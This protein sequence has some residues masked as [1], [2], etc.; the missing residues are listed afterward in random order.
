MRCTDIICVLCNTNF[1]RKRLTPTLDS[2]EYKYLHSLATMLKSTFVSDDAVHQPYTKTLALRFTPTWPA[3]TLSVFDC[4]VREGSSYDWRFQTVGRYIG[5]VVI[6]HDTPLTTTHWAGYR[7]SLFCCTNM[8]V[9]STFCAS[10]PVTNPVMGVWHMP[11]HSEGFTAR[12][13]ST[14]IF[15]N[16]CLFGS[17]CSDDKTCI[18]QGLSTLRGTI[19]I[20]AS[21]DKQR[22]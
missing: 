22:H 21:S 19:L 3:T 14:M 2:N 8:G 7:L 5:I 17:L 18:G 1:M 13:T 4:S 20:K 12:S 11:T 10:M 16:P 6:L 9:Y 15:L